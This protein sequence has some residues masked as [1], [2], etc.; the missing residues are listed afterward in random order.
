MGDTTVNNSV[1]ANRPTSI[2]D[3]RATCSA[4]SA[5]FRGTMYV[6]LFTLGMCENQDNRQLSG[7]P[8]DADVTHCYV[9]FLKPYSPTK[10][11]VERAKKLGRGESTSRL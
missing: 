8:G 10:S 9:N 3:A 7:S 6:A 1:V 5:L 11:F 4:T 2:D